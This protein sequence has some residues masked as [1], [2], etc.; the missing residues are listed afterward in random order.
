MTAKN[1]GVKGLR[2]GWVGELLRSSFLPLFTGARGRVVLQTSPVQA[3]KRDY[4][5]LLREH[6]VTLGLEDEAHRSRSA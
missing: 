2:L 3:A 4:A 1:E 6:A 5:A